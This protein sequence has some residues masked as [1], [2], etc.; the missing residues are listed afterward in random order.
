VHREADGARVRAEL[1]E[2]A[3]AARAN[4][5]RRLG[6]PVSLLCAGLRRVPHRRRRSSLDGGLRQPR[7]D[8]AGVERDGPASKPPE[9]EANPLT[10]Y[11][12]ASSPFSGLASSGIRLRPFSDFADTMSLEMSL[13][14][15][16]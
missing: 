15:I 13:A 10:V 3:A 4:S 14:D 2:A 8:S 6:R 1:V 5:P 16:P 11:E 7:A 12:S 9:I